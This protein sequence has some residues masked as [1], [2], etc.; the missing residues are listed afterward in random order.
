[1]IKKIISGGQTGAD[2]AALDVVKTFREN[3][4]HINNGQVLA[5]Y[6]LDTVERRLEIARAASRSHHSVADPVQSG[7][8]GLCARRGAYECLRPPAAVSLCRSSRLC[9]LGAFARDSLRPLPSLRPRMRE[10]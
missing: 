9:L 4:A 2:R 7:H 5:I 3:Y 6:R 1:M 8:Q 10:G